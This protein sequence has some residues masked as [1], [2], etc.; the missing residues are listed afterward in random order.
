MVGAALLAVIHQR[1]VEI[2][3]CED[4]LGRILA[5]LAGDFKQLRPV[6]ALSLAR[7]ALEACIPPD[8]MA[9]F[10]KACAIPKQDKPLESKAAASV[11]SNHVG[12]SIITQ[13]SLMELTEQMRARDDA[14][15]TR[16]LEDLREPL[17]MCPFSETMLRSL[18]LL[19]RDDAAKFSFAVIL[20]S[21]NSERACLNFVQAQRWAVVHAVPLFV[22]KLPCTGDAAALAELATLNTVDDI[23]KVSPRLLGMFVAGAPG[24]RAYLKLICTVCH[25]RPICYCMHA[26]RRALYRFVEPCS[27]TCQWV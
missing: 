10:L 27:W 26:C 16:M 11:A 15:H 24:V 17:A 9:A 5:V 12:G 14:Q 13:F 25:V 22:W 7:A 19:S 20:A 1:L 3:G 2:T 21:G 8:V 23:C 18:P 6:L 4:I